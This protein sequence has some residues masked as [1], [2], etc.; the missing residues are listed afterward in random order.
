MGLAILTLLISFAITSSG[1][2]IKKC[3]GAVLSA[4]SEKLGKLNQRE[5][6]NFLL[7]FGKECRNNVEYSEW[8]NELLFAILNNQTELSLKTIEK[9]ETS[10]DLEEILA[11]LGSPINDTIDVKALIPK[12]DQIQ[13][14][15]KLKQQ[16]LIKLKEAAQKY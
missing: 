11:D 3:D 4:T 14:N 9:F 5:I 6:R 16:I 12:V 8:S 15:G 7:T 2:E 1:Q 10:I 13:F